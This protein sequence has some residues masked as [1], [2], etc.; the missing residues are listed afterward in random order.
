MKPKADCVDGLRFRHFAK[1]WRKYRKISQEKLA[2]RIGTTQSEISKVERGDRRATLDALAAIAFGLGVEVEE[3]ILVNP[4]KPDVP[5]LVYSRVRTVDEP[6]Q[7][8]VLDVVNEM[9][10]EAS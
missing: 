5:K 2:E 7:Q 3:L 10:K 8:K 6:M 4:L 9:L 1:E